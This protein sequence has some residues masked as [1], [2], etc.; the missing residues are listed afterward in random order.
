MMGV[1]LMRWHARRPVGLLSSTVSC[2]C[3]SEQTGQ[4]LQG[5]RV[6][7]PD[8]AGRTSEPRVVESWTV[9]LIPESTENVTEP[10]TVSVLS[11]GGKRCNL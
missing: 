3:Q 4:P 1:I 10:Y 11:R 5:Q 2:K 8:P 9:D 7:R 6:A